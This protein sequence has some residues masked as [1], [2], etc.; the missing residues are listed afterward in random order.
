VADRGAL[1]PLQVEARLAVLRQIAV[2]ERDGEARARMAGEHRAAPEPFP[3]AVQRR[4]RELHALCALATHLHGAAPARAR[5]D[6]E[7]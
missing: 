1:S 2:V 3:R 5:P 7:G 4:L 6:G